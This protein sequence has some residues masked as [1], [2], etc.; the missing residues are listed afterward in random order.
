MSR[1]VQHDSYHTALPF[2]RPAR[3]GL[4][5]KTGLF[6]SLALVALL[7]APANAG[8]WVFALQPINPTPTGNPGPRWTAPSP[9]LGGNTTSYN[10][11]IS[12]TSPTTVS[13]TLCITAT[14]QATNAQD[15]AFQ[16]PTR[17]VICTI[18]QSCFQRFIGLKLLVV[19]RMWQSCRIHYLMALPTQANGRRK[20]ST[21]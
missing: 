9:A 7:G 18:R 15:A 12:S 2:C 13:L 17:R 11:W 3:L 14:W 16:P 4:L 8:T 19:G 6:L 1:P 5:A 10:T 21:L 20:L